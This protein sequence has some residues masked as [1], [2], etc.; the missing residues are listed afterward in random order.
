MNNMLANAGTGARLV[1]DM[2]LVVYKV[3]REHFAALDIPRLQTA[4]NTWF[5]F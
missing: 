3:V 4:T 2:G 1:D 5:A